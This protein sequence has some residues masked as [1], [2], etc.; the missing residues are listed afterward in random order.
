MCDDFEGRTI[1]YKYGVELIS[2][3]GGDEEW[4]WGMVRFRN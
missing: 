4:C 1:R 3:R 2:C